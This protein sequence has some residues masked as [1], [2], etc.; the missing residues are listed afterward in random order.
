MH[1]RN[2]AP[3]STISKGARRCIGRLPPAVYK[4]LYS[5]LVVLLELGTQ[6]AGRAVFP[7]VAACRNDVKSSRSHQA[8]VAIAQFWR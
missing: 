8:P 1:E 4:N 5:L 7:G 6:N 3:M 2:G